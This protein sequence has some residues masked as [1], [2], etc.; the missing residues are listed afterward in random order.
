MT[1]PK[2][3]KRATGQPCTKVFIPMHAGVSVADHSGKRRD[4]LVDA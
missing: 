1:S 3:S 4:L 2:I